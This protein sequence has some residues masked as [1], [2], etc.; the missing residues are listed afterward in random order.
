MQ[1]IARGIAGNK[2]ADKANKIITSMVFRYHKYTYLTQITINPFNL[3]LYLYFEI[4]LII[5]YSFYINK[6]QNTTSCALT[7]EKKSVTEHLTA[8][9]KQ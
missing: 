4:S 2:K 5:L 1:S 7:K 9:N 6:L 3:R 8:A